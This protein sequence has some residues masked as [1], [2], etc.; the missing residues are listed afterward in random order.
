[1]L[2]KDNVTKA[3]YRQQERTRVGTREWGVRRRGPPSHATDRQGNYRLN[4]DKVTRVKYARVKFV[5]N[6]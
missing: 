5:L 1:M 2:N 4:K 6:I 3:K